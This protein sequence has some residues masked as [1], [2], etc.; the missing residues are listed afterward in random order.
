MRGTFLTKSGRKR[1]AVSKGGD[2]K[3]MQRLKLDD[4]FFISSK[5]KIGAI[6]KMFLSLKYKL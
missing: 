1:I 3:E 4:F 2:M 5:D 6:F